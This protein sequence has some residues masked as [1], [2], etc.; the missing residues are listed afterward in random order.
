MT[1][2]DLLGSSGSHYCMVDVRCLG[3]TAINVVEQ[4]SCSHDVEISVLS[5]SNALGE[6]QHAEDVV[7][8]VHGVPAVVKRPCFSDGD[9]KQVSDALEL[10]PEFLVD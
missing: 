3:L 2:Q 4:H 8:V 6:V 1:N 9:H 5:L 7:E 10:L